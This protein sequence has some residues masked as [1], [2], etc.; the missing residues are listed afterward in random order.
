[1]DE[2]DA[3]QGRAGGAAA[4]D[5]ERASGLRVWED[6]RSARLSAGLHLV[7]TPIGAARDITLH[8]LDVLAGADLLAAEDTRTLRHLMEIHG[9]PLK[10]RTVLAHAAML[11]A[12]G[13]A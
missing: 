13:Q 6:G 1:M 2:D 4:A 10:G 11:R 7:A 9:V 3:E 12:Q 5:A 8:A